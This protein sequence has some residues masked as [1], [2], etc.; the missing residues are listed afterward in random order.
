MTEKKKVIREMINKCLLQLKSLGLYISRNRITKNQ[1]VFIDQKSACM[2]PKKECATPVCR[3]VCLQLAQLQCVSVSA[4]SCPR[5]TQI[6]RDRDRVSLCQYVCEGVRVF[7][8]VRQL[9]SV[10]VSFLCRHIQRYIYRHV[11]SIYRTH[12]TYIF[13]GIDSTK[14]IK[15]TTVNSKNR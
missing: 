8:I 13:V 2:L 14:S 12:I 10:L 15:R 6:E 1:L 3:C 11:C 9:G 7:S 5:D 4:V